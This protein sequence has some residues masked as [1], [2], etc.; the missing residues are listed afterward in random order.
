MSLPRKN[1]L[2]VITELSFCQKNEHGITIKDILMSRHWENGS[3]KDI[4]MLGVQA[5]DINL[6]L[7]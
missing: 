1:K 4:L 3:I 2:N 7:K 6:S 5:R